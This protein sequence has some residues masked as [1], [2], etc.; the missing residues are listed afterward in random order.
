VTHLAPKV[1]LSV[2]RFPDSNCIVVAE[3]LG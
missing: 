3:K 2:P 1:E